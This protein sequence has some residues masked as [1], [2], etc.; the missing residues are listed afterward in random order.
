MNQLDVLK[1]PFDINL[2]TQTFKHYCELIILENGTAVYAIPSH[3]EKLIE[4]YLQK[5]NITK[6]EFMEKYKYNMNWINDI[7]TDMNCVLVWYDNIVYNKLNSKQLDTISLLVE[8]E[9]VS[10]DILSQLNY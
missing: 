10:D 4:L 2:H 1:R 8:F 7:L 5:Y 3:H 9:A 6:Q